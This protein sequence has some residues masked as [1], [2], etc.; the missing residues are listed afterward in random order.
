MSLPWAPLILLIISLVMT[1]DSW[2]VRD[3][4]SKKLFNL[5]VSA[6]PILPGK[7]T[8]SHAQVSLARLTALRPHVVTTTLGR[9]APG[10]KVRV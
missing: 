7:I 4:L 2:V 6:K 8:H 10:A 3:T 9:V 1:L 5:T